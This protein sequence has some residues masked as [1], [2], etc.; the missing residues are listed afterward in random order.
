MFKR[1]IDY[2][3]GTFYIAYRNGY[4]KV[5]LKNSEGIDSQIFDATKENVIVP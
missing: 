4:K 5:F 1:Q 2:L 3:K